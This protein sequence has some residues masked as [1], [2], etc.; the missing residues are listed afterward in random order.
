M[1]NMINKEKIEGYL[2]GHDL[3]IKTVQNKDSENF[4]KEFIGGSI[5]I[6]TDNDC[7][8]VITINFFYVTPTT[9]A[10]KANQTYTVL[11]DI[12]KNGRT[13]ENVGVANATMVSI[14]TSL[15]LNEFY[16][17]SRENPNEEV[18]IASQRNEGGFVKK[19]TSLNADENKR[20]TFEFDMLINGTR[21]VPEK[22]DDNGNVTT[23]E[24]FELKGA[25]FNFRNDFLQVTLKVKNS[26]G[27]KYF[28]SLDISEKNPVMTKVWGNIC[29]ETIVRRKEEQAAF[30][31]ASVTEYKNKVKE[32]VVTGAAKEPYTIGEDETDKISIADIESCIAKMN[33][34]RAVI[35]SK[36][37]RDEYLAQKQNANNGF[38]VNNSDT[39]SFSF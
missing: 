32:W 12:I 33:E 14:D 29:S 7:L 16:A 11:A 21:M 35:K 28:E 17:P 37:K 39:P 26:G 30:G 38:I 1:K 25:I 9:K 18:L 31:E 34:R 23:P 8:N 10:G 20:N 15:G 6:A 5:D 19:I 24:Y 3:A 13:V 22:V 4:G 2:Y 27:I 36:S